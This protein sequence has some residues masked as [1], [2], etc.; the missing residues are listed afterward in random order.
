MELQTFG[1]VSKNGDHA[2]NKF[3]LLF[4]RHGLLIRRF[5]RWDTTS[6]QNRLHIPHA[7]KRVQPGSVQPRRFE[8]QIP[9]HAGIKTHQTNGDL[10]VK[11][12]PKSLV[13]PTV[14]T[15][16][17]HY[18]Q[19][20]RLKCSKNQGSNTFCFRKSFCCANSRPTADRI[21][22][23]D[24]QKRIQDWSQRIPPFWAAK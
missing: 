24:I 13:S 7:N 22:W 19:N 9:A 10:P 14:A 6:W 3:G 17:K 12:H 1:S 15:P 20:M 5:G 11:S 2:T 16:K 23:K 21:S 4:L 18:A 8:I